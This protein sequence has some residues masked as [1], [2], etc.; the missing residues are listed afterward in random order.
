LIG[1]LTFSKDGKLITPNASVSIYAPNYDIE[2]LTAQVSKDYE[3]G[4]NILT[5]PY[6]EFGGPGLSPMT[7]AERDKLIFNSWEDSPSEDPDKTWRWTG[8]RP[9]ARNK[10]IAVAAHFIAALLFP[11][12]FAQNEE[13]DEDKDAA[14]LMKDLIIYNI[15]NSNYKTSYLF[16]I[17]AALYNPVAYFEIEFAEVIRTVR[18]K[19]EDG[20]ITLKKAI[21]DVFSGF[22]MHS[23]SFDEVLINN[24]YEYDLQKQNSIIRQ[25]AI[26]YDEA[27]KRFGEHENWKHI[28]PGIKTIFDTSSQAFYDIVD[29]NSGNLVDWTIYYNRGE[30]LEVSFVNGI[31]V[32]ATAIDANFMRHRRAGKTVDGDPILVPIYPLI[33]FGYSPIDEGRFFFY[34]SLANE[35][36]PQYRLANRMWQM[37]AN[38]TFLDTIPPVF[39]TGKQVIKSNVF[40]PG[41]VTS[42]PDRESTV[43]PIKVGSNLNSAYNAMALIDGDLNATGKVPNLPAKA[44]TTAYAVSQ[45]IAQAKIQLGIFG[46]MVAECVVQ[47]GMHMIDVILQHQTIADVEEIT[48]GET[49]LKYRK[50][51]LPNQVRDGKSVTKV[52]QL[53]NQELQG[54]QEESDE[55]F[56]MQGGPNAEK[57]LYFVNPAIFRRMK[58]LV[59]IDPNEL[60]PKNE[61]FEKALALEFFTTFFNNPFIDQEVL[62]K[63]TVEKFKRGEASKFM[64]KPEEMQQMA[65]AQAAQGQALNGTKAGNIVSQVTGNSPLAE[66]VRA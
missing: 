36:G 50:F 1:I 47:I 25:R 13:D 31:Y 45:E 44:G 8:V 53:T 64:K 32:G 56:A 6:T 59:R 40:H 38:G 49:K 30:D 62:T 21:D 20:T 34:K 10:I 46:A 4:S 37:T 18:E 55:I 22:K 60:M 14:N 48:G 29:A 5:T 19:Q 41:A 42:L 65:M 3:T 54:T 26:T 51:I 35:L 28:R 15:D 66:M 9:T 23:V 52:I 58:F 17:V 16:G 57:E 7:V 61:I 2:T 63:E 43:T 24:A 27:K 33:K 39:I 11:N 12:I